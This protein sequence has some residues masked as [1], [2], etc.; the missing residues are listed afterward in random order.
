MVADELEATAEEVGFMGMRLS[1][2]HPL[3]IGQK[4]RFLHTLEDGPFV[5]FFHREPIAEVVWVAA[6][7]DSFMAG[8]KFAGTAS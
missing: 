1:L 7:A 3:T 8:L 4:I 6:Q 2:D 5:K